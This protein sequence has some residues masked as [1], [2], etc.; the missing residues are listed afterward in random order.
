VS[1]RS[2]ASG[3]VIA[4]LGDVGDC[5]RRWRG[6][7]AV[8]G[9]ARTQSAEVAADDGEPARLCWVQNRRRPRSEVWNKLVVGGLWRSL[10]AAGPVTKQLRTVR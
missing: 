1:L 7:R 3:S 2:S 8:R 6:R 9:A 10:A 5:Q 4:H